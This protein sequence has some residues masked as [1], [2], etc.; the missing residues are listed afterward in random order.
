[1]KFRPNT[2]ISRTSWQSQLAYHKKTYLTS[3][4]KQDE[5]DMLRR[6]SLPIQKPPCCRFGDF[7]CIFIGSTLGLLPLQRPDYDFINSYLE[8]SNFD[9]QLP[10]F[11]LGKN[12]E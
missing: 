6:R 12:F 8:I 9:A 3:N 4:E 1:M 10:K 5:V 7:F 2:R 11:E